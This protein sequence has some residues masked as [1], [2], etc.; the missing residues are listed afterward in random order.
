MSIEEIV[1][2]AV[3]EAIGEVDKGE[4]GQLEEIVRKAVRDELYATAEKQKE[5]L[6]RLLKVA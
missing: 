6:L 4:I 3:K 2:E 1:K 5:G